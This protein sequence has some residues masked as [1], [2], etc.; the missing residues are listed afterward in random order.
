MSYDLT[1]HKI[2]GIISSKE[3]AATALNVMGHLGIALGAALDR[4]QIM[5]RASLE[6]ASGTRH[7]GIARFSFVTKS[8]R[9][10]KLYQ[11]ITAARADPTVH[12]FDYPRAMLETGHDDELAAAVLG[13]EEA[14]LDYL[15]ALIFGPAAAISEISGKFSLWRPPD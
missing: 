12:L 5:G 3:S 14:E 8:A 15:G 2:V 11:A 6:D 4:D 13:T 7:P 9:P 10:S 1:S